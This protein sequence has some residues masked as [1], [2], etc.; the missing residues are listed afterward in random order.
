M[1]VGV[2][3]IAR[4][5]GSGAWSHH[6]LDPENLCVETAKALLLPADG[7]LHAAG[8]KET[9]TASCPHAVRTTEERPMH[10][11]EDPASAVRCLTHAL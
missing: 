3:I 2:D 1:P 11:P 10:K 8:R 5:R 4:A 6:V 7:L 9:Y